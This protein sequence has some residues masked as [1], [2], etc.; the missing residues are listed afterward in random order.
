M[1]RYQNLTL[2]IAF[3]AMAINSQTSA[4]ILVLE[5]FEYA[6]GYLH[7][8]EG[9]ADGWNTPW[10][11]A[12]LLITAGQM[13]IP[14]N[15]F[16][17]RGRRWYSS[18]PA[19][20]DGESYYFAFDVTLTDLSSGS[21]T[22]DGHLLTANGNQGAHWSLRLEDSRFDLNGPSGPAGT[23]VAGQTYRM[24]TRS[25]RHDDG[26]DD[27]VLWI[28]PDSEEDLP[29]LSTYSNHIVGISTSSNGF[30]FSWDN[31]TPG[32]VFI[33]NLVVTTTF[34]EANN[35]LIPEPSTLL[36]AALGLLCLVGYGRRCR[37]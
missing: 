13:E 5:T 31:G 12:G 37:K 19:P 1:S 30:G 34:A 26:R 15:T 7:R 16:P 29:L 3:V 17:S 33:D 22:G 21:V 20:I 25:T 14:A 24:I 10:Q 4:E 11:A 2:A 27:A 9:I 36:L 6:D 8:K 35:P 23:I 32:S 18:V 28:D